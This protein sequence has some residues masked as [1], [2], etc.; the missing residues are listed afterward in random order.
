MRF[1]GDRHSR[2]ITPLTT[3]NQSTE[4]A[5]RSEL[6]RAREEILTKLLA[7]GSIFGT[8]MFGVWVPIQIRLGRPE[9]L[10]LFLAELVLIWI[11]ALNRRLPYALRGAILVGGTYLLGLLELL[12]YGFSEDAI[13]FM[14][15][16]TL[17][18]AIFFG[19]WFGLG[20]LALATASLAGVGAAITGGLF[21]PQ[22]VALKQ[23]D[24]A[25]MA[26]SCVIF[27]SVIGA[28][29]YGTGMILGNLERSWLSEHGLRTE[30]EWERSNL[31]RRITE[32][33]SEL[34]AA[35]DQ[36][37]ASSGLLKSQN[38]YL[39]ALHEITIDL[40]NR[41]EL[42][43]LL[44]TSVERATS[45]LDA[46]Y[47][48]LMLLE[49]DD[50]V[51]RAFTPNLPALRNRR[52]TRAEMAGLWRTMESKQHLVIDT[53]AAWTERRGVFQATPIHASADFP[54]IAGD[55]CLGVLWLGRSEPERG[56][57]AEE[58]RQGM[59]F[60]QL[61]ALVID[62]ARLYD[63][64]LREIA[65]RR[66]AMAAL[67]RTAAA[68]QTQ[69]AE[70]DA[71]AHTVAHDIKNPLAVI[72]GYGE[73]LQIGRGQMSQAEID[74]HLAMIVAS[75]NRTT[76]IVDALLLLASTKREQPVA[77]QALEM[78]A[79]VA[80]LKVRLR[81]LIDAYGAT[82]VLPERWPAALGYGP[83]VEEVWANYLSNAIKY[84]GCPPLIELGA[85][86]ALDGQ[87]RFWVRD[88]GTGL[89]EG[90]QRRL[91]TSF[92]RLHLDKAPGH[93]LGLSIVQRVVERL[94]GQVG[95]ESAVGAGSRFYFTLPAAP[96]EEPDV[97]EA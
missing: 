70:L 74:E 63:T 9:Q 86:P 79:V 90:E 2:L 91:F 97:V 94:G 19:Q 92:T 54:V 30:L 29:L 32:R 87:V 93:G 6:L 11:S 81:D 3:A 35:R 12:N 22:I 40:L 21:A 49:G 76:A 80:H 42:G 85:D 24:P 51:V 4:T 59:A 7:V 46:T 72:V 95:V 25:L 44:Q 17:L 60:S 89:S 53:C 8:V 56:F 41:R 61:V 33:T 84:G 83:W 43:D 1:V 69:N 14:V 77:L 96:V 67:E 5:F 10:L 20:A 88:N 71:F 68:L 58:C 27:A 64:A 37:R 28:L 47:G 26:A 78:D 31:E 82:I 23:L 18:G 34:V 15:A 57:T 50:L 75:G 62:S 36:A 73:I 52:V 39:E 38:R 13:S 66:Q 65:E 48:A 55:A 45:I 16:F